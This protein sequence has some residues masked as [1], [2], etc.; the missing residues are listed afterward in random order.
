MRIKGETSP[1]FMV[2]R[3]NFIGKIDGRPV[4]L[5]T[6]KNNNGMIVQI[7]NYGCKIVT[8]IVP[9]REG[10]PGDVVLGYDNLEDYVHGENSFGAIIGR[11]GNR[12]DGGRFTL[13]GKEYLLPKNHG[14]HHIH[15][16]INNFSN[17][18]WEVAG[19]DAENNR[20]A[21]HY[22]SVDG[23]EGYPGN[24]DVT[25]TYTLGEDNGLR[26]DYK[27]TTD[28][29]TIVNLTNHSYFNLAG[30]DFL[31]IYDHIL[32]MNA[33]KF[34]WARPDLIPTG[35]IVDVAGTP[36]DFTR[37]M[38][39]GKHIHDDYEMIKTGG[40]YD[41]C[42]VLENHGNL[43]KFARVYDPLSGRVMECYT[44]EPGVQLYTSHHLDGSH[45]GKSGVAYQRH[46]AFCLETQ[47]FP[48]SPNKPQFPPVTLKPGEVYKSTTIY[49]FSV[50]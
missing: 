39:L 3:E 28:K 34:L 37:P 20:L 33:K 12:I 21:L 7:T 48:D 22:L 1:V 9:D 44:T 49:K 38:A 6:L 29:T 32:E 11:V 50:E 14:E 45:V 35:E 46:C 23:E 17:R 30:D 5:Y 4:D 27:A 47:H 24:L 25:M 43:M 15:G 10:N 40:G 26:L 8:V 31:P 18:V 36:M 41:V 16:G 42:Y 13:E 2:K 19:F